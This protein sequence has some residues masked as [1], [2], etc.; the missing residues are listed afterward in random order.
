V[1]SAHS[2]ARN[3]TGSKCFPIVAQPS[4]SSPAV[5]PSGGRL[6]CAEYSQPMDDPSLGRTGTTEDLGMATPMAILEMTIPWMTMP[7]MGM[8]MT[9]L[10]TARR[11]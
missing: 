1:R 9:I 3:K 5:N 10:R 11:A 2:T 8:V 7:E 6:A 4:P